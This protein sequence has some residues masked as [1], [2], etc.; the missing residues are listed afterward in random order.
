MIRHTAWL[1]LALWIAPACAGA[2]EAVTGQAIEL[3]ATFFNVG[4]TV[5]VAGDD[6]DDATAAL[7]VDRGDGFAPA[8]P[9]S[10]AAP[11][12]FAG[13]AFDLEPGSTVQVRVTLADPD[14]VTSGELSNQVTMRTTAVPVSS[15]AAYHVSP[16]G[17]DGAAGSEAAPFMTIARGL[18]AAQPGDTVLV[19]AG[20]YHEEVAVPRGGSA[21]APITLRAAGD[22]PAVMSGAE[23]ALLPADA[24]TDEGGGAY[25]AAVAQ[26]QYV[27]VDGVR[28]WRYANREE[29]DDLALG[30]DGGFFFDGSRVA[31]RL[32]RGAAPAGHEIQVATLNHALWLE[33]T[34]FVVVDGLTFRCYGA[35]EYSEAIMVR[36]GSHQVWIV[37]STFENVMPG[38]WV[39]NDVDDLVIMDNTFSDRGLAEFPWDAVKEQG[40]MESGAMTLD[41]A[42]DGQGIIF[43]RN[44]VDGS[45]DGLHIC[46]DEEMDHPNNADVMANAIRHLGD[47]GMETDGVCSNIRIIGNRFEEALCGVSLAPAVVGPTY[48]LRN[49][50]VDLRNVAPGSAWMTRALKFNVGDDRPSG[51]VFAYHNTAVTFEPEQAAFAVTD[52]SQWTSVSL[53]NN[54][55]VGTDFGFYYSNSGDEPFSEDYDLIHSTGDRLV[56]YQDGQYATIEE[57]FAATGQ[58]EHC[59]TADPLLVDPAGG[60]YALTEGSPAVDRGVA[61]PGINDAFEGAGPD[62]GAL[63]LG[64]EGPDLPDGGPDGDADADADADA[65]SDADSDGDSDGDGDGCGCRAAGA[66]GVAPLAFVIAAVAVMLLRSSRDNP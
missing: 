24:W 38:V 51:E 46:G 31:V 62:L 1:A 44:I 52:D 56:S 54:V 37:N 3:H 5:R 41:T 29:L 39:K 64:A 33:A 36:D 60:D 28:L 6:D 17:D 59:V 9:L 55:W 26:T 35:E 66:P 25:S 21:A 42:Y 2:Q 22:G 48:V 4:V 27:A 45:F 58:C 40:G 7:E 30:T 14:G 23:P 47:D 32:P 13:T 34:P 49:L 63:E 53:A 57:Y 8:H 43:Y 61:L 11:G 16:A 19:H 15:G 18:E 20:V 10:R 12:W 65:D 50:M